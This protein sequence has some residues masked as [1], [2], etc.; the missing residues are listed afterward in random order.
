M[1][2][3]CWYA[4]KKGKNHNWQGSRKETTIWE[5]KANDATNPER[6][7]TWGHSTQKPLDCMAK[8]I[9]N[10]TTQSNLVVDPFLG[11]GTTLIA[12]EKLKRKCYGME[13][14]PKYCEIICQRFEKLTGKKRKYLNKV[15][16]VSDN[17]LDEI[18]SDEEEI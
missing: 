1:H 3:P 11:S 9:I 16:K 17:E 10:N 8:P 5:I 2:E 6:E 4:V 12:A 18:L 14:E 15:K 13:L 7:E